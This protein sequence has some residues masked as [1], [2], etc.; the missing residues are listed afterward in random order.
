M[1]ETLILFHGTDA[2]LISLSE[3]ERC[4]YI[5]GCIKAI[6]HLWSIFKPY[7]VTQELVETVIKG[8]KAF[9][10]QRKIEYI[11]SVHSPLTLLMVWQIEKSALFS[12]K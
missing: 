4:A 9:V 6:K 10:L 1:N 8:N 5:E 2:R 3:T 7:Y 12:I 11:L